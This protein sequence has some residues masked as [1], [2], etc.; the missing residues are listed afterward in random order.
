M[1]V[2]EILDSKGHD[3][4]SVG[5]GTS[6]HEALRVMADNE[7]GSVLV[8]EDGQVRGIV[9]E[10]DYVRKV[11]MEGKSSPDTWVTDI[12]TSQV[13]C[14]RPEQTIEQAMALMTDK[15]VRHLP[16]LSDDEIVGVVS[17]GDLVK[18]VIS[19]QQFLIAQLES[20]INS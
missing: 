3:F 19:E 12:M 4:W 18:A 13:L 14:T 16:V 11:A 17:I 1:Q 9:T 20:Y 7:V 8:V 15:R 5:P 6:A 10:R 2:R